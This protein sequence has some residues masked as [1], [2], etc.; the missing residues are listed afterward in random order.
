MSIS[1][2]AHSRRS[3]AWFAAIAVLL[4]ALILANMALIFVLSH[5]D[6]TLSGDRSEGVT[7]VVVDVVYP[8]LDQRPP[9]EQKSLLDSLHS[10]IRK[11]AHFA[12]F[13]LLGLLTAALL[14]HLAR[15][16]F[17]LS[18]WLQWGIPSIFCLLYAISDEVHQIFTNRGP[19]VMDV[20]IDFGGSLVGIAL[21][22]AVVFLIRRLILRTNHATTG[23]CA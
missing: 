15:R 4:S 8:D 3:D 11:L 10:L 6:Q 7:N 22:R 12:E 1:S 14:V 13:A 20:L 18:P 21:L 9:A 2:P 19:A 5:E 23:A 17:C 16:I